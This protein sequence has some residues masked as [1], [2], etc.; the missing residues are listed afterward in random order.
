MVSRRRYRINSFLDEFDEMMSEMEQRFQSMLTG[1]PYM[2]P[3]RVGK[4]SAR[5]LPTFKADFRVDVREHA[6]EVILVADLPGVQK[7][8][9]HIRLM[10]SDILLITV[11]RKGETEEKEEGYYLRERMYGTMSRTVALPSD[12]TD[13]GSTATFKNGVLEVHLTKIA[14][15]K[16]AD[17]PIE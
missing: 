4:V 14:P 2:L 15:E 10:E 1:S 7:D 13:E 17:I 8:D 11:E 6:D 3:G 9:V 5:M 12:V 16:G